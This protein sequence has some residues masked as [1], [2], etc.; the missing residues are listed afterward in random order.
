MGLLGSLAGA[1]S[2]VVLA[3]PGDASRSLARGDGGRMGY[4][5]VCRSCGRRL[6]AN[7]H[8]PRTIHQNCPCGRTTRSNWKQ[9]TVVLRGKRCSG[10]G[11]HLFYDDGPIRRVI[12]DGRGS[13]QPGPVIPPVDLRGR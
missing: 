7:T 6:G 12:C 13:H 10:C 8:R 5:V 1:L 2:R 3:L 4:A 11:L 9:N